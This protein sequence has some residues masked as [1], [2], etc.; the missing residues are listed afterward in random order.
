[1]TAVGLRG[2]GKHHFYSLALVLGLAL[3]APAMGASTKLAAEDSGHASV[4]VAS[5]PMQIAEAETALDNAKAV[6]EGLRKERRIMDAR[7]QRIEDRAQVHTLGREFA[8]A[9][10]AQQRALPDPDVFTAGRASREKLLVATSN[11]RIRVERELDELELAGGAA[12]SNAPATI[13]SSNGVTVAVHGVRAAE[14][15]RLAGVQREL[16]ETLHETDKVERALETASAAAFIVLKQMLFWMPTG[17][18]AKTL[19]EFPAALEWFISSENWRSAGDALRHYG[20]S[21]PLLLA[22]L[23]FV[24]FCLLVFRKRLIRTL[25]SPLPVTRSSAHFSIRGVVIVL[26]TTL[27]LSVPVPIVLWVAGTLLDAVPASERFVSSLGL[28][29]F[30]TARILFLLNLCAWLLHPQGVAVRTFGW[31]VHALAFVSRS[32]RLFSRVFVPLIFVTA[33]NGLVYAPFSSRESLGRVLFSVAMICLAALLVRLFR[34]SGLPMQALRARSERSWMVQF[35]SAW[36]GVVVT[37]PLTLAVASMAGYF[38]AAEYFFARI[39]VSL[40]VIQGIILLNA[41]L[42]VSVQANEASGTSVQ[43]ASGR[44][45]ASRSATRDIGDEKRSLINLFIVILLLSSLWSVWRESLPV[46]SL[47]GEHVLWT[48]T[49]TVN[50]K[51]VVHPL[52]VAG[53]LMALIIAAVSIVVMRNISGLLDVVLLRRV[54]MRADTSFAVK[55][56]ARYAVILT[57]VILASRK[58]GLGWDDVQWLVAALSVGLGF[59]LQEIFGNLVAGLIMLAERPVRIGDV[60]TVGDVTG[61]VAHIS[62]RATTVTD[63]DNKE[64]LIPNK[65]FVTD[66]VVNWTLSSQTT[67]LQLKVSLPR[68]TNVAQAEQLMLDVVRS[69]PDVVADLAPTVIF[70]GF[71]DNKLNFEISAFVDS[72][73]KRQRVQHELNC[74]V[75]QALRNQGILN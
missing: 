58:L 29:L 18:T 7:M 31:D 55:V 12:E 57:G 54:D 14:L 40:V 28:A 1:M 11:A 72:F 13:F 26:V 15:V 4:V 33:L 17:F 35:H 74:A 71:G 75:E 62:A 30:A 49:N 43:D 5:L 23:V 44:L 73:S 50:G 63:F 36:F 32:V 39:V 20:P 47:I 42:I 59:G 22:L 64:I 53:F 16:L 65:S 9:V 19:S 41:L 37:L 51:D 66:R 8:A 60:V 25:A 56:V 34:R 6:L 48:Y 10:V 67:R 45:L 68:V 52:T 69:N 27:A 61:T 46:L 21:D 3:V 70:A 38:V 24:S 2:I